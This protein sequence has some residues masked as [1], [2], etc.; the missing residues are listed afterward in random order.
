ME[1]D[2]R[3]QVEAP[4]R[5]AL[6]GVMANGI[7]LVVAVAAIAFVPHALHAD[8]SIRYGAVAAAVVALVG[9]SVAVRVLALLHGRPSPAL[10]DLAWSRASE[11]DAEDAMLSLLV[12][13]WVPVALALALA[14]LLWPHLTSPDPGV[15]AAVVVFGVPPVVLAWVLAADAWGDACRDSLARAELES[16]LRF[17]SYWATLGRH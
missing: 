1:A 2:P 15:S 13:G 14:L 5:G 9:Y 10:R 8:L 11:L 7:G 3:A 17:R 12:A 4:I 6:T 16:Q